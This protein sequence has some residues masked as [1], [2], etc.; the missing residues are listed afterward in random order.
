MIKS[1]N[2]LNFVCKKVT[3][4]IQSQMSTNGRLDHYTMDL[5]VAVKK[6]RIA[7]S[8]CLTTICE[9]RSMNCILTDQ[10][11]MFASSQ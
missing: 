8:K 4:E 7:E 3:F 6:Y 10:P 11:G 9:R 2:G 5:I 1:K